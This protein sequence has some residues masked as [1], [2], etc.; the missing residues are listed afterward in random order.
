MTSD[1]Q[2]KLLKAQESSSIDEIM[3]NIAHQW[4]Q[5]L[6]QINSTVSLIDKILYEKNIQ[7]ER[8]EEKLQEIERLTK[9]MSNTIDDFR[10]CFRDKDVKS[11]KSLKKII[12]E[13]VNTVYVGLK[14]NNIEI[15]TELEM[16]SE[17]FY[18]ENELKQIMIVLLNNAKDALLERNTFNAKIEV[19]IEHIDNRSVINISDN[20]GGITK[21]VMGKIFEPYYTTKHDSE[22]TGIGL[23]LARGIIKD[24]YDGTLDVK[25]K[26]NG[27]CFLIGLPEVKKNE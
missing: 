26:D 13:A 18:Y 25:N 14:D 4:R 1:A 8:L 20:A 6:S 2:K 24:R 17:S 27:S 11:K 12:M 15:I 7:D 22:G 9:F 19:S 10:G 21:S 5:P 16:S 3:E 23:H